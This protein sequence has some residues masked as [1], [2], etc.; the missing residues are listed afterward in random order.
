MNAETHAA[1]QD[2]RARKMH[3]PRLQDDRFVER[4]PIVPV[5]L[6]DEYSQKQRLP[7]YLHGSDSSQSVETRCDDVAEPDGDEPG[8]NRDA[9]VQSCQ[10]KLPF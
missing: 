9:D 5:V 7:W 2:R 1:P 4:M 6:A 10:G 8:G 3:L